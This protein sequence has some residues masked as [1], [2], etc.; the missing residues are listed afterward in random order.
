MA[1]KRAYFTLDVGYLMNPK[2]APLL[3]TQP[4]A[5][6]LHIQCIAYSAQHL[7]DGRVPV[8]LAMRLACAEHCDLAMLIEMGLL[9]DQND[10]TVLVHDYLEH[11]RS[12]TAVKRASEQGKRAAA[13]RWEAG[14]DGAASNAPSMPNP[15]PR[16]KERK[17]LSATLA[18]R[19]DVNTVC[20]HMAD[21]LKARGVSKHQVTQGWADAARLL[22]D[23]DGR[24]VGEITKVIDWAAADDFWS[25][26][27]LSVPKLREKYDQL[28]IK[29]L[30]STP[31]PTPGTSFWDRK[32]THD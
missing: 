12:S 2:I 3:D 26:N 15:M 19:P 25:S 5:V 24:P 32:V 21:N 30:G 27:I 29:A 17:T 11:Q 28:R 16:K 14:E 1:D 9:L 31:T 22:I 13:K 23:R 4:R 7:T 8:H 18:E 20:Q 6:L 10:G